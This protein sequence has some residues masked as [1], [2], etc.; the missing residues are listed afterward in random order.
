MLPRC[1]DV[2]GPVAG[3]ESERHIAGGLLVVEDV[4]LGV[5]A[6]SGDVGEVVRAGGEGLG[7]SV[8]VGGEAAAV[9]AG[10]DGGRRG[11]VLPGSLVSGR[12]CIVK[13]GC[14][15]AE[16]GEADGWVG[17]APFGGIGVGIV[18]S[19]TCFIDGRSQRASGNLL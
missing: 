16:G 13:I 9:V 11:D 12:V 1:A 2:H 18:A 10:K 19:G 6:E 15:G 4:I 8:E 14:V 7:G 17:R 5:R 3:R